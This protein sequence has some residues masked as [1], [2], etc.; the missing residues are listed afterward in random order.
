VRKVLV[1]GGT[2]RLGGQLV[3]RLA[4]YKDLAVRAF[5]RNAKKAAPLEISGAEL[6]LGRLEDPKSV[7][8]RQPT[9][10]PASRRRGL[11]RWLG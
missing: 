10:M 6:A 2:G 9:S 7:R 5:V 4:G 1:T 11:N 8:G 3:P